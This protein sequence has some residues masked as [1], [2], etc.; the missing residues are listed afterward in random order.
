[1]K[2]VLSSSIKEPYNSRTMHAGTQNII[3]QRNITILPVFEG[4]WQIF[5]WSQSRNLTHRDT[6][7]TKA[8]LYKGTLK[9][10]G[11][12]QIV[13]SYLSKWFSRY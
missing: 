9:R 10:D 3:I 4:A 2:V 7:K 12:W 11:H 1:M 6:E 5:N 8:L 13:S